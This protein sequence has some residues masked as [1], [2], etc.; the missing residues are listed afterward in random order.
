MKRATLSLICGMTLG[1]TAEMINVNPDLSG[2]P[3]LAGGVPPMTKVDEQKVAQMTRYRSKVRSR[4]LPVAVDNSKNK[5]HRPIFNQEGNSCAQASGIGYIFTYEMSRVRDLDAS[6]EANWYP[7]H[8]TWHYV[9]GGKNWGSWPFWG[10]DIVE[11]TGVPS[12]KDFGGAMNGG[13]G[14]WTKWMDGYDR[15]RNAMDNKLTEQITLVDLATEAG[16]TELKQFLYDY[17]DGSEVGGLVSFSAL[18]SGVTDTEVAEGE[19]KGEFV[20]TKWGSGGAHM[21]TFCGYDDS[22]KVDLNGDGKY[23]N[24]IDLSGDGKVTMRDWEI[25][26]LKVTNSWGTGWGNDGFA[27]MLYSVIGYGEDDKYKAQNNGGIDR[28]QVYAITVAKETTVEQSLKIGMEYDDR[29]NGRIIVGIAQDT[30]AIAAEHLDTMPIM[31]A[32]DGAGGGAR[33]PMLGA[34]NFDPI[35]MGY[36]IT[37]LVK[38][39]DGSKNYKL[40]V[41]ID[42]P[43]A[44]GKGGL[45]KVGLI[46]EKNDKEYYW[47]DGPIVINGVGKTTI[48][49]VKDGN[50]AT[51]E[52]DEPKLLKH[53]ELKALNGSDLGLRIEVDDESELATV[54]A[55]LDLEDGSSDTV[56]LSVTATNGRVHTCKGTLPY[57]KENSKGVLSFILIDKWGNKNITRSKE[58]GWADLFEMGYGG[59]VSGGLGIASGDSYIPVIALTADELQSLYADGNLTMIS[60][61]L[62]DEDRKKWIKKLEVKVYSGTT[63]PETELYSSDVLEESELDKWFTHVLDA[64]ISIEEGKN[65]FVGYS[66][67]FDYGWFCSYDASIPLEG[68]SNI[69]YYDGKWTTLG[70]QKWDLDGRWNIRATIESSASVENPKL[71]RASSNKPV[72]T[73]KMLL[74][75]TAIDN[76]KVEKVDAVYTIVNGSEKSVTLTRS[77]VDQAHFSG[78]LPAPGYSV[79]GNVSYHLTDSDGKKTTTAYAPIKW[80]TDLEM[81]YDTGHTKNVGN[82][83]GDVFVPTICL[84]ADKLKDYYATNAIS[85]IKHFLN[86]KVQSDLD[87]INKLEYQIWRSANGATKPEEK[88]YTYDATNELTTEGWQEHILANFITLEE[89]YDY[90][91]GYHIDFSSG[92]LCGI[93]ADLDITTDNGH[94][95]FYRDEWITLKDWNFTDDYWNLRALIE[96]LKEESIQNTVLAKEAGLQ[97]IHTVGKNLTFQLYLP[98]K[99][100]I[101]I[102]I[103]NARGQMVRSVSQKALKAGANT[104]RFRNEGFGNGIYFYKMHLNDV[105]SV[106]RFM[107]Q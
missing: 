82:P 79:K 41:T 80:L 104:L 46:D 24:D 2:E 85:G 23:T 99:S 14:G 8:F 101:L 76:K 25:G 13:D 42:H 83:A 65:Y 49:L 27:W 10:W 93:S 87:E 31:A 47:T 107:M 20:I 75:V 84:R 59:T 9:N 55:I 66:I 69:L 98:E 12:Y 89:K 102:Q 88:I 40:F 60:F 28:N 17:G 26:A 64:P 3:W 86:A 72:P 100:D 77:R 96:P 48:T 6:D 74:S 94:Y 50:G 37:E 91:I 103:F 106:G 15:Y 32:A 7:S 73:E 33:L 38:K 97:S 56:D 62:E 95:I 63:Y 53:S 16:L 39:I 43:T 5:Y 70:E 57:R 58:A 105:Q 18:S 35:E 11:K 54:Q 19:H 45:K 67:E 29:F 30:D 61:F 1:V 78:E 52:M 90:W 36:D 71:L 44:D 21:M 81:Y 68:K 51:N 4:A 92:Y 34:G 22:I